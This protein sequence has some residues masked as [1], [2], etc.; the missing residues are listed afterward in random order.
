MRT[1]LTVTIL[2]AFEMPAICQMFEPFPE[3]F[4]FQSPLTCFCSSI[5]DIYIDFQCDTYLDTII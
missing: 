1:E 4:Q 2:M 5:G 3:T